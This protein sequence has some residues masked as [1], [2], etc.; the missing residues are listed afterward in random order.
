MICNI[1]NFD[2]ADCIKKIFEMYNGETKKVEQSWV[3]VD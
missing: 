1:K 2:S 3:I